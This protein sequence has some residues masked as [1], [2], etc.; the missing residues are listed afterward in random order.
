ML[1]S[2]HS[3]MVKSTAKIQKVVITCEAERLDMAA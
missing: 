2:A 3:R 1:T